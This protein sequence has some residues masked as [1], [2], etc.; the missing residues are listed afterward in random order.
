MSVTT[1]RNSAG[2]YLYTALRAQG[3]DLSDVEPIELN[4]ADTLAALANRKVDVAFVYG[5]SRA[6]PSSRSKAKPLVWV[7]EIYP[8]HVTNFLMYSLPSPPSGWRRR[9]A[10]C[11]RT[12]K[13]SACRT[14]I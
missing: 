12:S 2:A 6:W 10:S 4:P 1:L 13:P 8:Y 5:R 7:D 9:G 14:A 3:P 11:S